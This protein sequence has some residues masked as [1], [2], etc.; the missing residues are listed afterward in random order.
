V[1]EAVPS[2]AG[3]LTA[4]AY[5]GHSTADSHRFT[6][7]LENWNETPP[8]TGPEFRRTSRLRVDG[9]HSALT[10]WVEVATELAI[11]ENSASPGRGVSRAFRLTRL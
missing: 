8:Q 4:R 2:P 9:Y 7:P 5:S 10:T 1:C 3:V 6:V 11:R